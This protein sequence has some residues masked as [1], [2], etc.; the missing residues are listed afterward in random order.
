MWLA[1]SSA[2]LALDT[3]GLFRQEGAVVKAATKLTDRRLERSKIHEQAEAQFRITHLA[4]DGKTP[5][6]EPE[7]LNIPGNELRKQGLGKDVTN[8]FLGGLPG[9]QKE[10]CDGL[11]TS[12]VFILHKMPA[13]IRTVCLEFFGDDLSRAVPAIVETKDYLDALPDVQLAG[14]E[15]LDERYVRAVKYSTKA[16]RRELPKMVLVLEC[17]L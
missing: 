11:I 8:K 7:T 4:A 5:E 6:G 3:L 12:A 2:F 13:H 10:G 9:V 14:M 16:P 17:T 1:S 15:H